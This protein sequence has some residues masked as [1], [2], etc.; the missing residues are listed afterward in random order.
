MKLAVN[1]SIK[2]QSVEIKEDPA[3]KRMNRHES[4]RR[5]VSNIM[6]K[7]RSPVIRERAST[8]QQTPFQ[9]RSDLT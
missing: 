8:L 6:S 1:T 3:K 4:I 7:V 2:N 5:S 9:H